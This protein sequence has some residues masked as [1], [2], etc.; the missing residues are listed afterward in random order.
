M[1]EPYPAWIVDRS[2]GGICLCF[3]RT[4]IGAGRTLKVQPASQSAPM[5]GVEVKVKNRR[6]KGR[7]IELGCEF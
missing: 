3:Q 2:Q 6:R 7:R 5:L 1:D 4:G